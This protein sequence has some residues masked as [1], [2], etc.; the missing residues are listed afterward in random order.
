MNLKAQYL[1]LFD[2]AQGKALNPSSGVIYIFEKYCKACGIGLN[3]PKLWD[4]N[5]LKKLFRASFCSDT[6]RENGERY[7]NSFG[8]K[9][10]KSDLGY[11]NDYPVEEMAFIAAALKREEKQMSP[12]KRLIFKAKSNFALLSEQLSFLEL[13]TN[14]VWSAARMRYYLSRNK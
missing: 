7:H 8:Q 10:P 14:Q 4:K 12:I 13:Q 3:R 6:C 9:S 11:K 1:R 2:K 5:T